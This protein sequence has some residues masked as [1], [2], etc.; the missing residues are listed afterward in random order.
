MSNNH[1]SPPLTNANGNNA[2]ATG[3]SNNTSANSR[4]SRNNN[5]THTN[6]SSFDGAT[7]EIGAVLGLRHE[8]FKMKATSFENFLD[9]V[10][11][12]V[13]SNL[14]D[15]GDLKPIFRK[16]EDPAAKFSTKLKPSKPVKKGTDEVDPVD[17]DI[18]K[19]QVKLYVSRQ[20]NLRRN[21]EKAFGL[22]WGQ[23]SS[24]LQQNLKSLEEFDDA[25]DDLNILWL[26]KATKRAVSGIDSKSEPRH[27]LHK[28]LSEL[29]HLKQGE[30]ESNDKF[31]ER[32]K[33][34]VNTV[35]LAQGESVFCVKALA[36]ISD[37]S[38]G[39]SKVE[40]TAESEKSKA[41]LLLETS[42]QKRY[43]Q[44]STRLQESY[45]LGT[46]EY[47]KTTASM[48]EV[49]VKQKAQRS[50][51]SNNTGAS[52]TQQRNH[53][54]NPTWILLDTCS[55]DNVFCNRGL[56]SKVKKCKKAKS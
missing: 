17:M 37:I 23:C 47:P 31:L 30:T 5:V 22:I 24:S 40:T 12:Y 21:M 41:I 35:E 48:Y 6:P 9:K 13:I 8:K 7:S 26:V 46:N 1:T 36:N 29:Y 49:M 16:M 52:F 44:L 42:D 34:A 38:T 4:T 19:E 45:A 51:R 28:A 2:S 43:G 18:Y 20:S 25:Y 14:K 33:S 11:T 50:N 56:L 3:N 54:I 32:F 39:I 53:V 55:T 27:I 10:S 15:G